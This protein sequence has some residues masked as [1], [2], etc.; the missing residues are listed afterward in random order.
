GTVS[1]RLAEARKQLQK[2]LTRRG[3]VLSAALTAAALA[4][5]GAAPAVLAATEPAG[6]LS[7]AATNLAD[8]VCRDLTLA[9]L[10]TAVALAMTLTVLLVGAAL[11]A[12]QYAP[13]PVS[14]DAKMPP[15][16]ETFVWPAV[17]FWAPIDE[18]VL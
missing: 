8:S 10:K 15:D 1:S 13:T 9:R 12:F 11:A 7:P 16:P 5:T 17:P 3:I 4:Q 2:R 6:N 14:P 18:Q